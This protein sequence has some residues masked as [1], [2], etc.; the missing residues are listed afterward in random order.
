MNLQPNHCQL[1]KNDF[2][3]VV[4]SMMDGD[5][6]LIIV[7]LMSGSSL[8][9]PRPVLEGVI[10]NQ[11]AEEETV[12]ENSGNGGVMRGRRGQCLALSICHFD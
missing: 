5:I 1:V 7:N 12:W 8:V 11:G 4:I 2:R 9:S 10:F 6:T 3:L